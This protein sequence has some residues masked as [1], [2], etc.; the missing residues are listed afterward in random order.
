M[1]WQ[2]TRTA[3]KDCDKC[4]ATFQVRHRKLCQTMQKTS[5]IQMQSFKCDRFL[6]KMLQCNRSPHSEYQALWPLLMVHYV[7]ETIRR[8]AGG[9]PEDRATLLI[10]PSLK[11]IGSVG[12]VPTTPFRVYL[13]TG[14]SKRPRRC[15]HL[16]KIIGET[17]SAAR[18]RR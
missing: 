4:V 5:L 1:A 7:G 10:T 17:T 15:N 12:I 11:R 8:G 14:H 6:L 3:R 18:Q 13:G 2:D 16:G 9:C